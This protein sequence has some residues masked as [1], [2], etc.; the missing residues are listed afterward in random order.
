LQAVPGAVQKSD[1]G[2][3]PPGQQ[4]CPT[5]PHV[6]CGDTQLPVVQI[7]V[8]VHMVVFAAQVPP[9][10]QPPAL[11]VFV[12]QQGSFVPPHAVITPALQTM[13][14]AIVSPEATQLPEAQ[15]PPPV[16]AFAPAQQGWPG[17]PQTTHCLPVHDPPV[18]HI[19]PSGTQSREEGSQQPEPSQRSPGQQGSAG[20]PQARQMLP[21]QAS[22]AP[23]QLFP[24]QQIWLG[25]P[26]A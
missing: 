26:H 25:P 10:Q 4:A 9:T 8:V 20:P 19:C 14:L 23:V 2:P 7:A 18:W 17:A 21:A 16:Q 15:Q 12:W 3:A 6:P 5:P 1:P 24:G 13:P 11:Q 22:P